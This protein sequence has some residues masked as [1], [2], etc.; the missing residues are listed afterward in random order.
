MYIIS[1][2]SPT[3]QRLFWSRAET[4][5]AASRFSFHSH[6][7][8][9]CCGCIP[10]YRLCKEFSTYTHSHA[11]GNIRWD[12]YYY[13]YVWNDATAFIRRDT[14]PDDYII[15]LYVYIILCSTPPSMSPHHTFTA[16]YIYTF[17]LYTLIYYP[18]ITKHILTH[19]YIDLRALHHISI[20][21][22][23]SLTRRIIRTYK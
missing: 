5:N 7:H 12:W 21:Q 10:L 22:N 2:S 11:R 18:Q 13:Y 20:F 14:K 15:I 16:A 3:F 19:M 23:L 17:L 9:S 1:P 4:G 6:T 8:T